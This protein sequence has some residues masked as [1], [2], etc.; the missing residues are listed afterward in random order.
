MQNKTYLFIIALIFVSNLSYGQLKVHS[1]GSVS[2]GASTTSG[3]MLE[4][5]GYNA[6]KI[7]YS[8]SFMR[9]SS[10]PANG[11]I[12]S[13]SDNVCF[14]DSPNGYHDIFVQ[15][16]TEYSDSTDKLDIVELNTG[17]EVIDQLE[18]K[19][20]FRQA[21]SV[22]IDNQKSYG[23]L[24]QDVQQ[25]LPELVVVGH[26]GKLGLQTTQ[27]IPF[28]VLGIQEQQLTI[29]S[30]RSQIQDLEGAIYGGGTKSQQT[31]TLTTPDGQVI[32]L[33]QNNP[34]PF[35]ESTTINYI[36]PTTTTSA[37]IIIYDLQ[38]LELEA[39]TLNNFGEGGLIIDGSTFKPGM[40]LY[41]L[42]V[43]G[44]Y[45]DSKKMILTK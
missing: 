32:Q 17:L 15:D 3:Y 9:F 22:T 7:T 4:V 20:Y 12:S 29:D 26:D 31:T 2:V 10:A 1:S 5:A 44:K 36:L 6:I 19:S 24:A 41:A 11:V 23:F 14:W 39:Y 30:L 21:D 13:S 18:P 8:G 25:V 35:K 28:L 43:D 42:I 37:Q 33:S 45:I 27:I 38:G 16:L 34:N 40:Y